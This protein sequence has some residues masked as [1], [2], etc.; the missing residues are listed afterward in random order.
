MAGWVGMVNV[1]VG[2]VNVGACSTA[3]ASLTLTMASQFHCINSWS[4]PTL[5]FLILERL[6]VLH[7]VTGFLLFMGIAF[8]LLAKGENLGLEGY[9]LLGK[10]LAMAWCCL[11]YSIIF[12][13]KDG[14]GF[15]SVL[16]GLHLDICVFLSFLNV[17]IPFKCAELWGPHQLCSVGDCMW[18][19]QIESCSLQLNCKPF[20]E[21]YLLYL[22][23]ICEGLLDAKV[24]QVMLCFNIIWK[25]KGSHCDNASNFGFISE[26]SSILMLVKIFYFHSK[27]SW[28][29]FQS[30]SMTS[31]S[32]FLFSFTFSGVNIPVILE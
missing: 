24:N 32:I 17:W 3:S 27:S 25:S 19:T 7:L 12:L 20:L 30:N 28:P 11:R 13:F 15:S 4:Y 9:D 26:F 29:S 5:T 1:A 18:R 21:E 6:S 31:Q 8:G 23:L 16:Q 2:W 14:T 10:G 22:M